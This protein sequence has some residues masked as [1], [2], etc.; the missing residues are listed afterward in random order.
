M[1]LRQG[2]SLSPVLFLIYMDRIVKNSESCGGVK[3][4]DYTVQCLLFADDLVQTQDYQNGLQ[5]TLDRFLDTCS[6]AGMKISTTSTQT[7]RLS[8]KPKHYSLQSGGV[9]LKQ[10]EKFQYL[11]VSFTSD[12]RRNSELN[13]R[14]GK[15]SAEMRQLHRSVVLKRE[16]AARQ[17]YPFSDQSM[18]LFCYSDL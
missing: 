8:G 14:I 10:S 5:Q 17:N 4:G 3:I 16:F 18:F 2:C 13:I 7:M 12:G 15:T 11:G 6:I 9:T 1:G